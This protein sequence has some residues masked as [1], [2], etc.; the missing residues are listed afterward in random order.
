VESANNV[1]GGTHSDDDELGVVRRDS[2]Q[3]RRG[4]QCDR[5][6]GSVA[7]GKPTRYRPGSLRLDQV[8]E[9]LVEGV[10][11]LVLLGAKLTR[12]GDG[13][14]CPAIPGMLGQEA[15][16][17]SNTRRSHRILSGKGARLPLYRQGV[18]VDLGGSGPPLVVRLLSL[19]RSAPMP[20]WGGTMPGGRS[21]RDKTSAGPR[22]RNP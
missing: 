11:L 3:G 5:D 6:S 14:R 4:H 17:R 15:S 1:L 22:S 9:L 10:F 8:R 16:A 19:G 2:G 13:R 20:G 18:T 21:D 7:D 12:Q